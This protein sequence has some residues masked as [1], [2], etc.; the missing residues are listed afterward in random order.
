M[1]TDEPNDVRPT[2]V[3][4][5][6]GGKDSTAVALLALDQAG[7]HA[8]FV[9]A[10]TGNEHP[11][12]YDY[13]RQ[14]LPQRLGIHIDE[15]RADFSRQIEGKR[16]YVTEKWPGKGVPA[17]DVERA[18]AILQP[19]GNAFLDLCIWKG[20][21]PSRMAQFCTQELKRY[22]LDA[23][24]MELLAAGP[25]ESWRGVRRDESQNRRNAPARERTAEGYE[26]VLPIVDWTADQTV[27]FVVGRGVELNPLYRLGMKRV[28]CMPC[29]NCG[30]GELAEIAARFPEVVD[31][32]REWEDIVSRASKRGFTTFFTDSLKDGSERYLLDPAGAF[33]HLR[34]DNR[35]RWARTVRG[36]AQYDLLRTPEAIGGGCSSLYGL[37]E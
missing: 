18:L 3:V 27:E 17:T 1:T 32:I 28:G 10:D 26:I 2:P 11:L 14:Y 4:S 5:L 25:V 31:R 21:F 15:V 35:V 12:T 24:L 36:G 29:I 37:C 34:I 30:K 19:T 13:V 9:F 6:S 8:R 23:H 33:E 22:P 16:R 7:G 20:R